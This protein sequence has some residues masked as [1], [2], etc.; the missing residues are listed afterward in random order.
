L[1]PPD[2]LSFLRFCCCWCPHCWICVVASVPADL[3]DPDAPVASAVTVDSAFGDVIDAVGVLWDP[4]V[5][6]ASAI[7]WHPC[8]LVSLVLLTPLLLVFPPVLDPCYCRRSLIFLFSLVQLSVLCNSCCA[9]YVQLNLAVA[10]IYAV[11]VVPTTV[12]LVFFRRYWRPDVASVPVVVNTL[13]PPILATLLLLTSI[14]VT[15]LSLVL[16]SAQL[17]Q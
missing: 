7:C 6:L 14:N 3:S 15:A 8:L 13:F 17:L 9:V 5:V 4:S 2:W 12:L 1:R 11:D 10:R 16:L